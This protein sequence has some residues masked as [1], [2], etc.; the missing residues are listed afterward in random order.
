MIARCASSV[1]NLAYLSATSKDRT[2]ASVS[3][4]S[5]VP[6]SLRILLK[7]IAA[8]APLI[9]AVLA[10][11]AA[12]YFSVVAPRERAAQAEVQRGQEA[13]NRLKGSARYL[14]TY[15]AAARHIDNHYYDQQFR[16]FD[17]PKLRREWRARAAE[18]TSD[19]DLYDQVFFQLARRFP[20]SHVMMFPPRAPAAGTSLAAGGSQPCSDVDMGFQFA[21]FR[22]GASESAVVGE[23]WSGSEA[24]RAGMVPGSSIQSLKVTTP[25]RGGRD[26]V[27]SLVRLSPDQRRD[28]ETFGY[29]PGGSPP[30]DQEVRFRVKCGK[31]QKP[32]EARRL[33]GGAIYIRFDEFQPKI[34][35]KVRAALSQAGSAGAVLDL[36]FNGGGYTMLLLNAL[37][38]ERE[39][40][41]RSRSASG[42]TTWRGD[43]KTP[44][45]DGPLA[46][47]IGP[48]SSSAA[49]LTAA[50]LKHKERGVTIGRRTNGSVLGSRYYPLPDGGKILVPLEEPELLDGTRLEGVGTAPDLEVYPT[51]EQ[52]R[53]G[54]DPALQV[55]VRELKRR[56]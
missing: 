49:E 4:R 50:V 5:G 56:S 15:D 8:V 41:Y 31:E 38:P 53:S 18:A 25:L 12:Y 3:R 43:R 44:K 32:F 24:A 30:P 54:I 33:P 48:A 36:R 17:W 19:Q 14:A 7:L 39:P 51:I 45:Y 13:F 10:M 1:L 37:F 21:R 40:I 46:V 27:A 20:A 55:A 2:L 35:E 26:V 52:I 9:A 6:R 34:L 16:G 23:V 22:R 29:V 47:L 42:V 28:F 11:L